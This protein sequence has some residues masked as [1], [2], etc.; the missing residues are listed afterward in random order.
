MLKVIRAE[1]VP[2][3]IDDLPT[4]QAL[5]AGDYVFL[6][7]QCSSD[8]NGRIVDD[9]LE[10]EIKRTFENIRRI[11]GGAGLDLGHVVQVR[12]YL[13]KREDAPEFNQIYSRIFKKPYPVRTTLAGC[14]PC[15]GK[16][17]VDVVA[18]AD[19]ESKP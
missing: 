2:E 7:A 8:E 3:S 10:G 6:S 15:D 4:S 5:R 18:Y 13:A 1:H 14:L 19:D 9:T 11:L 12:C 17:A 16:I